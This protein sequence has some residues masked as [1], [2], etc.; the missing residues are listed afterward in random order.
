MTT[1]NIYRLNYIV[2]WRGFGEAD[3]GQPDFLL[4][5]LVV[6]QKD[7]TGEL[8]ESRTVRESHADICVYAAALVLGSAITLSFLFSIFALL[9]TRRSG[10]KTTVLSIFNATVIFVGIATLSIGCAVWF[11]TLR[12]RAEFAAIWTEQTPTMQA[13]L[14][15]NLQCCGYW[16]ASSA[17]LFTSN[18]GFCGTAE[19][20]AVSGLVSHV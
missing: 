20:A 15:D 13:W 9:H 12:P 6:S 2:A 19:V 17:G 11:F 3:L 16:N 4:R 5:R 8:P 18:T 1:L 14:Q 7:T 10:T